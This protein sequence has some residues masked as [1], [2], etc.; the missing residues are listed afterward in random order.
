MR[1][2]KLGR[3][4]LRVSPLCLGTMTF[5]IQCDEAASHAILDKAFDSGIT[6][7]DTADVYPLGGGLDTVG[8]TEEFIGSWMAASPSRR[9]ET[10]LATKFMGQMGPKPWH[11]GG[12]RKHIFEAVEASL[13]RLGT[14]HIDLYQ[15]HFPDRSTPIEETMG[16]LDDLVH[17]GKVGYLGCSNYPAWELAWAN[18]KAETN[19]LT[20]YDCVQPRYNA[21]FRE[22]ERDLFELCE[23][24]EIA[25][26]PYN[27]IAGGL[28]SGKHSLS[29]GPAE[30]TRFTLGTA[31]D[32]YQDRYWKQ[33]EFD[34]IEVLR[35]IADGAGLTMA[36]MA[37]GWVLA[38][39]VITAPIVGASRPEQL[40]DALRAAATPLP[41]D[42]KEAI[43]KATTHF[44]MGDAQ[45]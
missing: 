14:D 4:G 16:A 21:L 35:P 33:A 22:F 20:R 24:E 37:F 38:N 27:P 42:V 17:S 9:D 39:P 32:R 1:H 5:G 29:S 45:R 10:V 31:A 7:L 18:G 44:R 15:I 3:T 34:A 11:M 26:I 43:D 30:G 6:F 40:D 28:L 8:R 13:R 23:R 41:T 19:G 36:E 25:V 12:S 2:R